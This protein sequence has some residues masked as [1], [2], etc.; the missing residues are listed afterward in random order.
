MRKS[1]KLICASAAFV[2]IVAAAATQPSHA[3]GLWYVATTGSDSNDCAT[4]A[5]PCASING[6]FN[7]PGI[8]AGDTIR[9]AAGTYTGTGTEVVALNRDAQLVGGWNSTFTAPGGPST[10]DGQKARRGIGLGFNV[11]AIVD[12]FT[13]RNGFDD[14]G[15]GGIFM[16]VGSLTLINSTVTAN[17]ARQGG[18]GI[19]SGNGTLTVINSTISGNATGE[20]NY[21]SGTGAGGIYASNSVVWLRNVTVANNL[22]LGEW[23]PR[24]IIVSDAVGAVYLTNTIIA[25]NPP[26]RIAG[27][28]C[29]GKIYSEGF[30]LVDDLAACPI[31]LVSGDL[32]NVDSKLGTLQDNGG[33]TLT[34]RLQ[35][36]SPAINAGD[37]AGCSDGTNPLPIDQRGL[38]R[39]DRCDIGAYEASIDAGLRGQGSFLPGSTSG[40]QITLT[41]R[42]AYSI[43]N[44]A[45][46]SNLPV[47][48]TYQ[49]GT[50]F[51][52][53][54]L[55]T[56]TNDLIE[57]SGTLAAY[58]AMTLTFA[59]TI[60]AHFTVCSTIANSAAINGANFATSVSTSDAV[61]CIC[62]LAKN[63]SNPVLAVGPSG[64]WDQSLVYDPAVLK[65]DTLYKMWYS[66]SNGTSNR[67][68]YATSPDGL[69]WTKYGSNPVL[70]P[71]LAWEGSRVFGP[72]VISDT[73]LY[74]MWYAA[75]DG[76][77]TRIGYA[78]SPDGITWT[79]QGNPV[80]DV[81]P[82]GA[83]YDTWDDAYVSR[84]SVIK[85]DGTYH[86]WYTGN[87]GLTDRIGHATSADGVNWSKD[88][89]NPVV[90]LGAPG[91]WDWLDTY[92][93][94]VVAYGDQYLMWYSGSTL[95][96]AYQTGFALST[97][98][99]AWA[100]QSSLI[101]QGAPGAFDSSSAD[102]PAV[103]QDGS[104][105]KIWYSGLNSTGTYNIGYATAQICSA[106]L[107]APDNH[108][109]YLPII[110]RSVPPAP[111]CAPYYSDNF[112][113]ANSGWY[114][115]DNAD[116][117]YAY[118]NGEYQIWAKNPY[119]AWFGT[120]GAKATNFTASVSARRT[121]GTSGSYG[122]LFGINENWSHFYEVLISNNSVSVW[123][124]VN[125]LWYTPQNWTSSNFIA[126]GTNW[127]RLKV[128]R[129]GTLITVY[130][131]GQ[132]L[133]NLDDSMFVG[134]GRIGLVAES[135]DTAADLRFDDFT[136]YPAECASQAYRATE[137]TPFEMGQPEAR[138]GLIPPGQNRP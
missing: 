105:F 108:H 92:A 25:N 3:S 65:D 77:T 127:N 130:I 73:G 7:K 74:K 121:N 16:G 91:A 8:V 30:N 133:A 9:V 97:D 59:A 84:P 96:A 32:A 66:G 123:R 18:G 126:T 62:G 13:I 83:G 102:Y 50:L 1:I 116:R 93:A 15:G 24:A 120:A 109:T 2:V 60:D 80:L 40:Y 49:S 112:S 135:G 28:E 124:Y 71:T 10:I 87:D 31:T 12:R 72:T 61:P 132:Q 113:N 88:L 29:E 43:T 21:Y 107:V 117:K 42:T 4:P 128:V 110:S 52:T 44:L 90:D 138:A 100:K 79:K 23:A 36:G 11:T 95:P 129:N 41:N 70:A 46:T 104:Q 114:V 45:I 89:A 38:P 22:E 122:L 119:A 101:A 94:D 51:A 5:T 19:Y 82:T 67:I 103:I 111:T 48:L 99:H 75:S 26:G 34:H 33:S 106:V 86:L 81:G 55:Y 47:S 57:W 53:S 37:P 115:S 85:I 20:A 27:S 39:L 58:E 68:G 131:N 69:T 63:A 125:G 17:W 78:T 35:P 14:Y 136:L 64:S 118:V 56:A 137:G 6:A 98:G 134:L 76:T 54:G